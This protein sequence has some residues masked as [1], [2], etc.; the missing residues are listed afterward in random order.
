MSKTK[1][2]EMGDAAEIRCSTSENGCK[3][4]VKFSPGEH[5]KFCPEC[6]RAKSKLRHGYSAFD[7]AGVMA[8]YVRKNLVNMGD[9]FYF[10]QDSR[11]NG[12]GHTILGVYK[13]YDMKISGYIDASK[14]SIR[15]AQDSASLDIYA[16]EDGPWATTVRLSTMSTNSVEI[17]EKWLYS[18]TPY[19]LRKHIL[20]NLK[21]LYQNPIEKMK[22]DSIKREIS[23]QNI[24]ELARYNCD[25]RISKEKW[26]LPMRTVMLQDF[27]SN[28]IIKSMKRYTNK[29]AP[30]S[31]IEMLLHLKT[32]S[33][34]SLIELA[35]Y[36]G[37]GHRRIT[38]RVDNKAGEKM[39]N[40]VVKYLPIPGDASQTYVT[41][42]DF[43]IK[44]EEG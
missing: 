32:G 1:T 40:I 24:T 27:D 13:Y 6:G 44:E 31:E 35:G 12:A 41:G 8:D 14:V 39:G 36:D 29:Q 11:T 4:I 20:A 18:H 9:E 5:T 33:K 38:M 2:Y 26:S 37:A 21:G 19:E 42:F 16:K 3:G 30:L 17:E 10:M 22:Y 23:S 43:Y 28:S 15:F 7:Y 34:Y 25:E